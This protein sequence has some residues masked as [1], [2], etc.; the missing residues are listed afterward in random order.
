LSLLNSVIKNS[1]NSDEIHVANSKAIS[2][3]ARVPPYLPD[4]E[5][6]PTAFVVSI[7]FC[8]DNTK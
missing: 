2:I 4:L 6:I 3:C 1:L 5:I 8:G 7:H